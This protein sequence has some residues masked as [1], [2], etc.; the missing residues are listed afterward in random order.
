M[1]FFLLLYPNNLI[2]SMEHSLYPLK[3]YPIFK[4]RIW[5]GD[6]LYALLEKEVPTAIR[7]GESWEISGVEGDISVVSEGHLAGNSLQELSD[8]YMGDLLGDAVYE[9]FGAEFPLLIKFIDAAE[10]LSVQV[11]P[12]DALAKERHNSFGKTE[13]WYVVH[14]DPGSELISGFNQPLT[15][16]LCQKH[17]EEGTLVSVLHAEPVAKGDI[18]F[19]PAGRVHAIGAGVLV[20][21]I[22]QTSDITYRIFDWNR[23]DA[24][25]KGRQLH[26]EEALDAIDFTA[27]DNARTLYERIPNRAVTAVDTP[28]FTTRVISSDRPVPCD[29]SEID[30]FV[31]YIC[32]EGLVRFDLPRQHPVI[33][34][35]GE[36]LLMPAQLKQ[37]TLVPSPTATCLEVYISNPVYHAD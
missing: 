31:I 30:S 25:G 24:N 18:F 7:A 11:H 14:A 20:A 35:A 33:L 16:A 4:D 37:W 2:S 3:F 28:W 36:T 1:R 32:T 23:V 6:K 13:M 10:A 29:F 8:I 9:R 21:E 27:V 15:K 22:Q 26:T 12:N 5:A 19:M 17:V 34:F